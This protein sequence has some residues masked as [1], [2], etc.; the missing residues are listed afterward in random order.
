MKDSLKP[1]AYAVLGAVTLGLGLRLQ[2]Q[3]DHNNQDESKV[4]P[5]TLP[6]VL[7][8]QDGTPV[9]TVEEWTPESAGPRS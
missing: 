8:M 9:R 4:P 2:A 1:V 3:Q 7:T 6:A 5:Y